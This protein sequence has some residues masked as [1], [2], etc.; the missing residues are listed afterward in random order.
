MAHLGAAQWQLGL[1]E[2]RMQ[3]AIG[4][5]AKG[6]SSLGRELQTH[7]DAHVSRRRVPDIG[8]RG[9]GT[10]GAKNRLQGQRGSESLGAPIGR[11][12]RKRQRE[13]RRAVWRLVT[14]NATTYGS[15]TRQWEAWR[16]ADSRPQ[17]LLLQELHRKAHQIPED[18][19]WVQERGGRLWTEYSSHHGG[20]A[21]VARSHIA[22]MQC[23]VPGT[24]GRACAALLHGILPHGIL[25]IS[26]YLQTG[27]PIHAQLEV[28][29]RLSGFLRESRQPWLLAGDF[30][31]VPADLSRLAFAES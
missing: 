7:V 5:S 29:E 13:H 22:G 12:Y 8:M 24:A 2:S 28:L 4:V 25:V 31:D 10:S 11:A 27:V 18:A 9:E 30:Q 15:F 20:T 23:P 19:S 14:L 26:V 1:D 16:L 17:V 21:I 3:S 6:C